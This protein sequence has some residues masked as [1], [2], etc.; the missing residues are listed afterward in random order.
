MFRQV[1]E[2]VREV[3]MGLSDLT[4]GH[5]LAVSVSMGLTAMAFFLVAGEAK[6]N[7]RRLPYALPVGYGFGS[8]SLAALTMCVVRFLQSL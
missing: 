6:R 4:W 2:T 3:N 5:W 7:N 8:V 1:E